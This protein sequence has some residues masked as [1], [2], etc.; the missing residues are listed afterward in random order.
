MSKAPRKLTLTRETIAPL[1]NNELDAVNGGTS[2][3]TPAISAASRATFVA[4]VPILLGRLGVHGEPGTARLH[5][6]S[7]RDQ[8]RQEGQRLGRAPVL[9]AR[10]CRQ[11]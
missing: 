6:R 4:S 3:A 7:R 9:I 8:H 2:P 10:A 1:H 5:D 11:P